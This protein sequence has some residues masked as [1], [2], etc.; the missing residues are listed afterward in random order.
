MRKDR[1]IEMR[2]MTRAILV[3]LA[4]M[5]SLAR[6]QPPSLPAQTPPRAA[7]VLPDTPTGRQVAAFLDALNTGERETIRRFV[8][9]QFDKPPTGGL[10]VDE[11][12]D[13][14]LGL[15]NSTRGLEVR[16]IAASSSA[17]ITAIVQ[18]KLTECWMQIQVFV[19]AEPP[20]D[21]NVKALPH[22]RGVGVRDVEM[23]AELL[24]REELTERDIHA[25]LDALMTR[26]VAAD[27]FSGTVNLA[28][29][30]KPLY[31][32]AFGLASRSWNAGNKVDTKFN[33]ASITKMFTAVAVAQLVEQGKL[34]QALR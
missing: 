19:D 9:E 6:A 30:G 18:S 15:Y 27:L 14:F 25:K 10:S 4:S 28:K 23:P 26:L 11:I 31:A 20:S 24:P 33:L 34:S 8:A 22:I 16:K 5:A 29:D 13:R 7:P 1:F 17:A 21:P 12:T 32:R 3:S 2:A